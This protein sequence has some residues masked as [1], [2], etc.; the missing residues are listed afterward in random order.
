M[1]ESVPDRLMMLQEIL[2]KQAYIT[3]A[4]TGGGYMAETFGLNRGCAKYD[5]KGDGIESEIGALLDLLPRIPFLT[6]L[7]RM[8]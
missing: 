5:D 3:L 4:A 8:G 2:Q 6:V 7:A 1:R